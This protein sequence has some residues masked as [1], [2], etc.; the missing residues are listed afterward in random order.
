MLKGASRR[1][2]KKGEDEVQEEEEEKEREEYS[3][4]EVARR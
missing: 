3:L 4:E 2:L 1:V